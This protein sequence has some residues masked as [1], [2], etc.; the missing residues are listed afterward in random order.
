M[1]KGVIMDNSIPETMKAVV[2]TGPGEFE[3]RKVPVPEPGPEEVLCK[4]QA[5]AICGSDPKMIRGDTAGKWPPSY[6]FIIGHEWAG[7]IAALGPRVHGVNLGDRV[8]GEA[9]SGCGFCAHCKQGEYNLCE[10]YGKAETGHRHYGHLSS[11]AY[12]AYNVFKVRSLTPLPDEVSYEEGALADTAGTALHAFDLCGIPAGGTIV[13][14]GPGPIG[15]FG[16]MLAKTFGAGKVIMVGRGSRLAASGEICADEVVNFETSDPVKEVLALTRGNGADVVLECSGAPG[17]M[18]QGI[19]MAAR[20]GKVVLV[21]IPS[22]GTMEGVP[23]R[24]IVLDQKAVLG[25]RAN[26]NASGRI[27]ELMKSGQ[28]QAKK[29]ITHRFPIE[30][31]DQALDLFVQRKDGALKV[32]VLPND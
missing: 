5:V 27:L 18:D 11:G 8:A 22:P 30:Q 9:H 25:S 17:T 6:P 16:G 28:L 13:V 15:M 3:V 10:N 4:V 24:D 2:L 12:A 21:G 1:V 26:P 7:E 23:F 29:L 20:G 19:R 14:I 31:F 32:V